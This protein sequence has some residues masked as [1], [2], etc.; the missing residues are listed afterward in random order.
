[1]GGF[2]DVVEAWF[3]GRPTDHLELLG[4]TMIFWGRLGKSMLYLA[5]LSIL[6]DL[7]D[8]GRLRQRG[9]AS[10]GRAGRTFQRMRRKRQVGRLVRMHEDV[11]GDIA[12]MV[13]HRG[14]VLSTRPPT[15]VP[16]GVRLS[17]AKY[18]GF[19][20]D[21]IAALP[22]EHACR[23]EHKATLCPQQFEYVRRRVNNLIA[24]QLPA[25]QRDLV[26]DAEATRNSVVPILAALAVPVI[27]VCVVRLDDAVW[28]RTSTSLGVILALA[29]CVALFFPDVRLTIGAVSYRLWGSALSAYGRLLDQTR[30]LHLLRWLAAGLFL[31]GGPLDLL[32]S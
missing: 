5:G 8:P 2:I 11:H 9:T 12:R 26:R 19:R 20:A 18:R 10:V 6:L 28:E 17:L 31:I 29:V 27:A 24:E 1:M 15:A 30:P 22:G 32:A 21:V 7:A 3:A 13:N 4:L 25:D 23:N 16:A 14:L